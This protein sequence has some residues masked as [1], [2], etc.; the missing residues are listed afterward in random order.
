MSQLTTWESTA[1]SIMLLEE[2]LEAGTWFPMDFAPYAFSLV[3]F[4]QYPY[5]VIKPSCEY[6]YMLCPVSPSS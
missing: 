5:A 4:V 6:N 1:S 2:T 3:N